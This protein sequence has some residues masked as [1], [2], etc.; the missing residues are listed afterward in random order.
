MFKALSFPIFLF[1]FF[2]LLRQEWKWWGVSEKE[3]GSHWPSRGSCCPRAFSREPGTA[4]WQQLEEDRA[5]HLGHHYTQR[6]R[7]GLVRER[8]SHCL[9]VKS[10]V[11]TIVWLEKGNGQL[12]RGSF[13]EGSEGG[14]TNPSWLYFLIIRAWSSYV[15]TS[16]S[17]SFKQLLLPFFD[18]YELPGYLEHKFITVTWLLWR[19]SFINTGYLWFCLMLFENIVD[20]WTTQIWTTWVHLH[21]DFLPPLPPWERN[22]NLSSFSSSS[23]DSVWRWGGWDLYDDSLPLN[24]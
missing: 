22:T 13:L 15:K 20:L 3:S 9:K 19:V 8:A 11:S 24:E 12:W 17:S 14:S 6:S 16:H 1:F 7:W 23:A 2:F 10:F 5:A 4:Q 21:S 18:I